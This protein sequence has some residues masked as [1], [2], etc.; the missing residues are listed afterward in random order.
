GQ[1]FAVMVLLALRGIE[2]ALAQASVLRFAHGSRGGK[3]GRQVLARVAD[4][5]T[6]IELS[7]DRLVDDHRHAKTERE[8]NRG[9]HPGAVLAAEDLVV[10]QGQEETA[11]AYALDELAVGQ[12]T[13]EADLAFDTARGQ[14]TH[15]PADVRVLRQ[16]GIAAA[17]KNDHAFARLKGGARG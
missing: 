10:D 9:S 16:I 12:V 4:H 5:E 6:E 13:G 7:G 15:Q 8:G 1:G 3:A 17:A 2:R 14:V 11:S